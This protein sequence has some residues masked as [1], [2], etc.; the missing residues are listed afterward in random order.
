MG[1]YEINAKTILRKYRKIDSWFLSRYGMNLYRGCTHNCVYCDGRS[2]GYYMKGEFG[3]DIAVKINAI[4]IL[5]GEL[6]RLEK[7]NPLKKGFISLGGGVGDSY[8]PIE[9]SYQ[10][11]RKT[12]TLIEKYNFPVH[13][14]SKS[15]LI[16]R[17][18]DILKKINEKNRA[19]VSLSFSSVNDEIGAIFEPGVSSPSERLETLR[20]FKNE[21]IPCG[22]FLL[23]VIPFI[24]DKLDLLEDAVRKASE[25]GLDFI[26][27]GG[28]TL[29]E[30]RQRDYF[31]ET[32]K[33]HYPAFVFEYENLFQKDKYG[34]LASEYYQ[35]INCLFNDMAKAFK[36]SPRIPSRLYKDIL[37]ENDLIIVI[38]E[39]IDYLLKIRG[40]RSLFGYAAYSIS[41]IKEPLSTI[42]KTLKNIKGVSVV[43][44]RIIREILDTRQSTYFKNLLKD[45]LNST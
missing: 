3:K 7:N 35:T 41:K 43:T 38:L 23:P 42:R 28:M 31:L 34:K 24:T 45:Y 16:K 2:E 40:K 37:E 14:L 30:G 4:E 8:Q 10:L 19:I 18:I 17:D 12:L 5:Q 44:E 1:I 6:N 36:I 13:I 22:M 32:L 39:H 9:E 20:L 26:N 29:K 15:T 25:I 21:G 27:F 11:T 33:K